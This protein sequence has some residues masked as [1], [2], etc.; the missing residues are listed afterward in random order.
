MS[1]TNT[2]SLI[3]QSGTDNSL[4]APPF[5]SLGTF[6][7]QTYYSTG[8]KNLTITGSLTIPYNQCLVMS[9][10][11]LIIGAGGTLTIDGNRVIDGNTHAHGSAQ[12]AN[13][14]NA[15]PNGY[16]GEVVRS[17]GNSANPAQFIVQNATVFING[18]R[19][20][21]FWAKGPKDLVTTQ[22]TYATILNVHNNML[23]LKLESSGTDGL[24][25]TRAVNTYLGM[26]PTF[27]QDPKNFD[28]L[29]FGAD[30]PVISTSL[31]PTGGPVIVELNNYDTSTLSPTFS[32]NPTIS[33]IFGVVLNLI[34]CEQGLDLRV[35][36]MTK[37]KDQVVNVVRQVAITL[38]EGVTAIDDIIV[39]W[40]YTSVYKAGVRPFQATGDYTYFTDIKQLETAGAGNTSCTVSVLLGTCANDNSADADTSFETYVSGTLKGSETHTLYTGKYGYKKL[41]TSCALAGTK[42][43]K[44]QLTV[45]K[46][47]TTGT[48]ANA[49]GLSHISLDFATTT[50]A[51]T[52][53]GTTGGGLTET[54]WGDV[55]DRIQYLLYTKDYISQPDFTNVAGDTIDLDSWD[56]TIDNELLK[57]GTKVKG[58]QT[59][60]RITLTNGG[61]YTGKVESADGVCVTLVSNKTDTS[62]Y[63][64]GSISPYTK[65]LYE[66][67]AERV[68]FVVPKGTAV[69]VCAY[70]K[71]TYSKTFTVDTSKGAKVIP[72]TLS[73]NDS[74][75]AVNTDTYYNSISCTYDTSNTANEGELHVSFNSAMEVPSD[76]GSIYALL[77]RIMRTEPALRM[78]CVYLPIKTEMAMEITSNGVIVRAPYIRFIK[79][80]SV[81]A[82]QRVNL[83]TY[84]STIEA[85]ETD[86]TYIINPKRADS[87][88]VEVHTNNGSLDPL[89]FAKRV[90][91]EATMVHDI[92]K[93]LALKLN[94]PVTN[95]KDGTVTVD[96]ITL[97]NTTSQQT[98]P[99]TGGIVQERK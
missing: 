62:F 95:S 16:A 88:Y 21:G 72:I 4:G 22:G 68:G 44:K 86:P 98:P 14:R 46:A 81:T 93:R 99:V 25:D 6:A 40:D 30:A 79:G 28:A 2:S 71:N 52:A 50:I 85:R 75:K 34:N 5:T 27:N 97:E 74:I 11:T 60:G 87:T 49:A 29:I 23:Q 78:E 36:R 84:F 80:S 92:H 55:Y 51:I 1:Y 67:S 83:E 42:T 18:P 63:A 13:A 69:T 53:S 35:R 15:N 47:P 59:Q 94:T 65:Y 54:T 90:W 77:D 32:G 33:V 3:T 20:K 76:D 58:I 96:N 43:L 56:I 19:G 66:A 70:A 39:G 57:E 26:T 61:K 91:K 10:Q 48:S 7:G 38:Q 17:T 9:G 8:G 45:E 73:S 89:E 41:A 12:F 31:A 82:Q 24:I 37:S 64:M